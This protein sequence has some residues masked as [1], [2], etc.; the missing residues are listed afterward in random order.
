[1][2]FLYFYIFYYINMYIKVEG[3]NRIIVM[4][5]TMMVIKNVIIKYKKCVF[6]NYKPNHKIFSL[7][8]ENCIWIPKIKKFS[9]TP[10]EPLTYNFLHFILFFWT[11]LKPL[12]E[13]TLSITFFFSF[14]KKYEILLKSILGYSK[15]HNMFNKLFKN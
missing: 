12:L 5:I 4:M 15:K 1:M 7:D 13:F 14:T 10:S 11:W 6:L 3:I 9:T 2:L 8:F